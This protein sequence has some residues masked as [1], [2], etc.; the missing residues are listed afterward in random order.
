MVHFENENETEDD[1]DEEQESEEDVEID[2]PSEENEEVGGEESEEDGSA[3]EDDEEVDVWK[4]IA[5]EAAEDDGDVVESYKRNVKLCRSLKHD[6]THQQVMKS[7][8][9]ARDGEDMGFD[10]ALDFAAD[11]SKFL[12]LKVVKTTRAAEGDDGENE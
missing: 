7:L 4:V 11:K 8:K 5:D 3:E 10:E 2:G 6:E 9:R 1:S 12:I